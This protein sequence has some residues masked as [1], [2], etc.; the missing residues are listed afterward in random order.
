MCFQ[1][2]PGAF[3]IR[4]ICFVVSRV[5]LTIKC[6]ENA[7]VF[8]ALILRMDL[9]CALSSIS[10]DLCLVP[11]PD[12]IARFETPNY[13]G[14]RFPLGGPPDSDSN[15]RAI[16]DLLVCDG[17]SAEAFVCV[18]SCFVNTSGC[19]LKIHP[20]TLFPVQLCAE[21]PKV[22]FACA[23]EWNSTSRCM[24]SRARNAPLRLSSPALTIGIL[25]EETGQ[26]DDVLS[27]DELACIAQVAQP[28]LEALLIAWDQR[29]PK[30]APDPA[31][32]IFALALRAAHVFIVAHIPYPAESEYRYRSIVVDQIPFP[33]YIPGTQDRKGLL[34]RLRLAI[35]LLTIQNHTR[36]AASLCQDVVWPANIVDRE[37]ALVRECTGIGIVTPSPSEH[38]NPDAEFWGPLIE[39]AWLAGGEEV[40]EVAASSSDIARSKALV[41][42]WLRHQGAIS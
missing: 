18:A 32:C 6:S 22:D 28:H 8:T 23:P 37:L 26:T 19:Q 3:Y 15:I 41:T 11:T 2:S 16:F 1:Y 24:L 7:E 21:P 9:A 40:A 31:V 10:S 14:P 4:F 17:S 25:L 27:P 39:D 34:A 38:G 5:G 33:P 35:S 30:L 29:Y 36:R 13:W 42:D 12:L 20:Q